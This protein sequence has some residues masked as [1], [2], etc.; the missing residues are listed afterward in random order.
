MCARLGICQLTVDLK[1]SG[2]SVK[3]LAD[4]ALVSTVGE[5]SPGSVEASVSSLY[6][7]GEDVL[8]G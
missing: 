8:R 1:D 6:G 7:T 4:V 3:P 2:R 5:S